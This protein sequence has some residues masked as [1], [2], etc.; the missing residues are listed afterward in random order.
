[1]EYWS[2]IGEQYTVSS[3]QAPPFEKGRWPDLSGRRDFVNKFAG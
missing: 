2:V 3:G 1:M